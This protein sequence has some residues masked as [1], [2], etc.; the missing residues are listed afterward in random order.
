MT[1]I[2]S[3][4]YTGVKERLLLRTMTMNWKNILVIGHMDVQMGMELCGIEMAVDT[5]ASGS[6]TTDT[7]K[8][9]C[10]TNKAKLCMTACT[11]TT[12]SNLFS[13]VSNENT[14]I[15]KVSLTRNDERSQLKRALKS[16]LLSH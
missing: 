9:R 3:R 6:L 8:E 4:T 14:G 1:D 2:G 13:W 7:A 12:S 10:M 11:A 15:F 5:R 16:L